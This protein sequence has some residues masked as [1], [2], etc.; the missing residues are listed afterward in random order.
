MKETLKLMGVLAHPDDETLG[1]GG[2]L[3]RYAAQ[4][5]ET[6]IVT[7]TRGERG[8]F[9]DRDD[10][11]GPDELGRLREQEL[12]AAAQVLGIQ[13]VSLLGYCDGE[14][15]Q[16]P[17]GEVIG[18]ICRQIRKVRPQVIVTFDPFGVYGHPDHIAISQFT[19]AAIV[20]AADPGYADLQELSAHRVSKLYYL[21]ETEQS[22]AAYQEI[23]G[24]LV[25]EI[26]GEE[27]RTTGWEPWAI[28]T[29][30]DT[31]DYAQQVWQAV[32]CHRSQMPGYQTLLEL[33]EAQRRELW[34]Q[35]SF[36]RSFSLVNGGRVL[37]QDLFRG[38]N[39][40]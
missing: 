3:A 15:D 10:Y 2:V 9:G 12:E 20:A 29:I 6:S 33:P 40:K 27:R 1:F 28:T 32:A 39:G 14:L 23:F 38:L 37:E 18:K 34:A 4:G 7:A 36:Y 5:V 8:W 24:D 13:E 22:L 26:D 21:A 16:A 30:I 19:A 25:M 11:P 35:Q 31:Q 17:A